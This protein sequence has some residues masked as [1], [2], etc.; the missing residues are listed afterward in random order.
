M[1]RNYY[2]VLLVMLIFV[3]ISFVSNIIDPMGTDVQASFRLTE[4]QTGYLAT[5]L[6]VAYAVMSI[7]AGMLVEKFSAKSVLLLAFALSTLGAVA[8][9]LRPLYGMALPAFFCIGV[10]FAMMQV[11]I[12]PLLRVAGGEE[13][14]AFWGN[15]SQ[16][17]FALGS[18]LSPHLYSWLVNGL[19]APGAKDGL[20]GVLTHLVP[21]EMPWVSLYWVFAAMLLAMVLVIA[22]IRLPRMELNEDEKVGSF[23]TVL[24]LLRSRIVWLYFIGII[25]YVGTEQGVATKIKSFLLNCH[26][27]DPEIANRAVSGFWGAMTLGCAVGLVLLKLVD[28]RKILIA[29]MVGGILTLLAALF[30]PTKVAL[31]ALPLMGFW[32]S[33][34]WPI[35][36]SLALNSVAKHHGSFAGILCT[37]ILGGA[38][39]PPIVGKIA[40]HAGP[41]GLRY[42]MLAVL[43][44]MGY[45]VFLGLWARP[46]VNNATIGN[47]KEPKPENA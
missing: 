10:G 35:V 16:M 8:F 21:A 22:L 27:V 39:L 6:F 46:L 12:N 37:G 41:L 38:L 34:G 33:I 40:D 32:C 29:F 18:T 47:S 31:F 14:Y 3:V 4:T 24:E 26:Q 25:C 20:L 17:I 11:I 23:G 43:A 1:K 45:L 9:A 5:A 13:H 28:S 19:K 30:G 2:L 44:T 7:P 36:F 42:G 15:A